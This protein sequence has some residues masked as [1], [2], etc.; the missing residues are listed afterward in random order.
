[1]GDA[2]SGGGTGGGTGA[3][4]ATTPSPVQANASVTIAYNAS[5]RNLA[6]ATGVKAHVGFN[7]WASVVSPDAAMTKG[8]DG[9]WRCSLS[10]PSTA[11]QLDVVFNDGASTWDNNGGQDWHFSVT[12]GASITWKMD[13]TLDAGAVPVATTS[14]RTLWAGLQGDTLYLATQDAGEGD[15]VFLFLAGTSGALTAAP[16]SK[17]GQS[18]QWKAFL[19]DENDNAFSGWFNELQ[20]QTFTATKAVSTGTN[21]G[22][23]EGTIDIAQLFGTVP[24]TILLAAASY[25]T[26]NAGAL[27]TAAQC[28]AGNGN[29]NIEAAEFVAVRLCDPRKPHDAR[30]KPGPAGAPGAPRFRPAAGEYDPWHLVHYAGL[31]CSH[32]AV[33]CIRPHA[34]VDLR[35]RDVD[36]ARPAFHCPLHR[37]QPLSSLEYQQRR[38]RWRLA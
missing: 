16:W 7:A 28:P 30:R 11:T 24:D 29:A 27:K 22:V 26:A 25:G 32:C 17:G 21:G 10:V 6:S 23:L 3:V 4:V 9:L 34:E 14:G 18:M 15:D 2:G 36:D 33:R 35:E 12:G 13:G 19:A 37:R 1:V 5:G 8:A 20:S 38:C 31:R